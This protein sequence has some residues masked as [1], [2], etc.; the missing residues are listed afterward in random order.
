VKAV[1]GLQLLLYRGCAIGAVDRRWTV[2]KGWAIWGCL[3][4]VFLFF[5]FHFNCT[6]VK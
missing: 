1:I 5:S 2:K 3:L 6:I 4:N